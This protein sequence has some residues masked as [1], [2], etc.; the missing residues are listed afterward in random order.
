MARAVAELRL[1]P[2]N[3]RAELTLG[4]TILRHP[5][6]H[7]CVQVWR[8]GR[9]GASTDHSCVMVDTGQWLVGWLAGW[10]RNVGWLVS[11]VG[12]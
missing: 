8:A 1:I 12:W 11:N 5:K 3:S 4:S 2:S 7:R 6:L 10:G 9:A